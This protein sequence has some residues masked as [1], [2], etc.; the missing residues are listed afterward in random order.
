M[1][2][3]VQRYFCVAVRADCIAKRLRVRTPLP[4]STLDRPAALP[5]IRAPSTGG[6]AGVAE[7][8]DAPDSKSGS[9]RSVGSTPTAR[10]IFP[11][12]RCSPDAFRQTQKR[13]RYRGRFAI[14][15]REREPAIAAPRRRRAGLIP[16]ARP[17]SCGASFSCSVRRRH[18][19]GRNWS[20]RKPRPA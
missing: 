13:P 7:L 8:A 14:T 16:A 1:K 19:R 20:D 4:K 10:T 15:L 6:V 9:E 12:R 11:A 3:N 2:L 5:M 17:C 18:C